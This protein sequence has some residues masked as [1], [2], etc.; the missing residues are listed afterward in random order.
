MDKDVLAQYLKQ[1]LSL[2]EIGAL[3]DRDP[4]TVG[5]WVQKHGL[6]ANGRSK[7]APRG[8]L[9]RAELEPLLK[10]GLTLAQIAERVDRNI[11]TVRYWLAKLE[12]RTQQ[13]RKPRPGP[14]APRFIVSECRVHGEARFVL[15]AMGYY[16]CTRCRQDA[17]AAW[18]RRVKRRLVTE[19][20]G[21][22]VICGYDRCAAAL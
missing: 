4:S 18:R 5:Y 3:M 20:G 13:R 19:A 11:S 16:R 14:N 6:V 9:T 8:G 10:Q 2:N 21:R 17:V 7:Y 12:L 22:C 1:G 15:E